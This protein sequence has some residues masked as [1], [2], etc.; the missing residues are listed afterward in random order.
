[1]GDTPAPEPRDPRNSKKRFQ[2]ALYALLAAFVTLAVATRFYGSLRLQTLYSLHWANPDQFDLLASRVKLGPWSAPLDDVFIHFDFAR[3]IARGY[4]FQWSEGNGYSSGGTSLLY[5]FV[6]AVGYLAGFRDLELMEWAAVCACICCFA[7]LLA[8]R[9]LARGLPSAAALLLPLSLYSVGALSWSLFSGMEVALFVALWAL[10]YSVYDAIESAAWSATWR[11]ALCLG[12]AGLAVT[13]TRPEGIVMVAVL[14]L[15]AAWRV[16]HSGRLQGLA[17]AAIAIAPSLLLLGFHGLMNRVFTGESRAAGALVKLELNHPYLTA[18]QVFE[19]WVFHVKY[20]VLRVTHYHFADVPVFGYIVWLFGAAALLFQRTRQQALILWGSAA[21]WVLFVALNGQVRWQNERYTMPAV[22]LLLFAAALGV[23]GLATW[24]SE[25]RQLWKSA[26]ALTGV[27]VLLGLFWWHQAPRYREQLWFFGRASRNIYDQHVQVGR[28]LRN[29]FPQPPKRVLVGDAGAIP[30]ISD[31]PALDIIGLGGYGKLPFARAT[32]QHVGAAIE[33]IEHIPP[34]AR[35]D[36]LAIYPGWW[37]DFPVWFGERI[38][39]VPV[40]GNVI[41]GG[42]SKVLYRPNWS[43]LERSGEPF[44]I[45]PGQRL[46]DVLDVADLLSEREHRQE[47]T[48]APGFVA[49]KLLDS[50]ATRRPLWDAGRVLPP[51]A[52]LDFELN[53]GGRGPRAE[54]LRIVV[55]LTHSEGVHLAL[56]LDGRRVGVLPAQIHDGWVEVASEPISLRSIEANVSSGG[57]HRIT[58]SSNDHECVVYHVFVIA[59]P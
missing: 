44:A 5:P 54:R 16:R 18:Q 34:A 38:G 28:A 10:A 20:Q 50:P 29:E 26:A 3:S 52:R 27:V 47:L 32:R 9:R 12:G 51:G 17:V 59:E 31:L 15:A 48:G 57:K 8:A 11:S 35:P 6:L 41:C 19:A 45:A 14:A 43:P 24:A 25:R 30:Y 53:A 37:G 21:A 58:L 49:M 22:A 56:D 55:R 33:L 1:M 4:P 36:L 2:Q 13:A 40:R 23:G 39:E 7:A 46:L 42:A